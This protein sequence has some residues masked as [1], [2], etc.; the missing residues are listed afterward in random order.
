VPLTT[1]APAP[2]LTAG[3]T[4]IGDA[5]A[6]ANILTPTAIE[7]NASTVFQGATEAFSLSTSVSKNTR[8]MIAD[9]VASET[10]GKRQ[11]QASDL[12]IMTGDLQTTNAF[13]T[14]FALDSV[15]YLWIRP[16]ISDATAPAAAQKVQ[17]A[18]CSVDALDIREVS[19]KDGDEFAVVV[20]LSVLARTPFL[21][22][23]T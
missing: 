23:V 10:I 12:T 9:T 20:K 3:N 1:Y 22:A 15:H 6:I 4:V 2:K 13:V 18:K 21:V 19:N 14:A 17:V 8:K 7:L 11:Y 5:P 16:G